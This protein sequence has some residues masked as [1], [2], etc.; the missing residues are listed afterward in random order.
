[1]HPEEMHPEEALNALLSLRQTGSLQSEESIPEDLRLLLKAADAYAVWGDALPSPAFADRLKANLLARAVDDGRQGTL[2]AGAPPPAGE[3]LAEE[4]QVASLEHDHS[5]AESARLTMSTPLSVRSQAIRG[6]GISGRHGI[7]AWWPLWP[8][9]VVAT[10][11]SLIIGIMLVGAAALPGD[12]FYPLH[13]WEQ[14]LN[15]A[16]I[17][18]APDRMRLHLHYAEEGLRAVHASMAH[19]VDVHAYYD[20]L[21]TFSEEERAAAA[22]LGQISVHPDRDVLASQ[23]SELQTRGVQELHGALPALSWPMRL[24]TTTVLRDLGAG[25]PVV[26]QAARSGVQHGDSYTWTFTLTGSGFEAGAVLL[27]NG[28]AAGTVMAVSPTGLVAQLKG[29]EHEQVPQT[30]GIG[31]LDGTAAATTSVRSIETTTSAAT[32]KQP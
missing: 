10:V 29:A 31:N 5:T 11:L 27:V 25:V 9:L 2:R 22:E 1:M 8:A 16:L 21:T 28:Q 3:S 17:V 14:G 12:R 19:E 30:V 26:T 23:L 13:R 15:T 20:A 18:N 32:R 6:S 24:E 4:S 7:G